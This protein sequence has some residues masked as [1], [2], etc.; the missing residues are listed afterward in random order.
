M[1]MNEAGLLAARSDSA[2]QG[3]LHACTLQI[4][5]IS[6]IQASEMHYLAGMRVAP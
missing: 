3:R 4:T 5:V 2:P 6:A 1:D